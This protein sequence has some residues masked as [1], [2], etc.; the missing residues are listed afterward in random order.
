MSLWGLTP[1]FLCLMIYYKNLFVKYSLVCSFAGFCIF[2]HIFR[3][4]AHRNRHC[5]SP[6][7]Y[8]CPGPRHRGTTLSHHQWRSMSLLSFQDGLI[9]LASKWSHFMYPDTCSLWLRMIQFDGEYRPLLFN[10]ISDKWWSRTIISRLELICVKVWI[11]CILNRRGG[12][13]GSMWSPLQSGW[14]TGHCAHTTY[15]RWGPSLIPPS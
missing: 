2:T 9:I 14:R 8:H 7:G 5:S 10:K 6:S 13:S 15:T 12:D 11:F 3:G 4:D 1:P